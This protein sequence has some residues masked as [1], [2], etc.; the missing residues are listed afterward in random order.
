MAK[1]KPETE[2]IGKREPIG[3][4]LFDEPM[5]NG[6]LDQPSFRG[7]DYRHFEVRTNECDLSLDRLG[8]NNVEKKSIDYLLP[9]AVK[10]GEDRL[11]PKPFSGWLHVQA[12]SLE[13]GFDGLKFSVVPSPIIPKQG[14]DEEENTHHAHIVVST[15]RKRAA[16]YIR[17]IYVEK[18]QALPH[19]EKEQPEKRS[20]NGQPASEEKESWLTWLRNSVPRW[21]RLQRIDSDRS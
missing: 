12:D 9:K 20:E 19:P 11:P 15:D 8:R 17:Q 6:A 16:L 3:R 18:G 7:I 5:L 2:K 13:T 14:E 1:W 21:L 10:Q 4:R